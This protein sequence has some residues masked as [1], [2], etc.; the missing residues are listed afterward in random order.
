METFLIDI[1]SKL[2]FI[3][4]LVTIGAAAA[5]GF[6]E[7]NNQK[8]HKKN[9]ALLALIGGFL[10]LLGQCYS[11]KDNDNKTATIIE[12][13]NKIDSLSAINVFLSQG[14]STKLDQSLVQLDSII[15]NSMITLVKLKGQSDKYILFWTWQLDLKFAVILNDIETLRFL[16]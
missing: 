11:T 9:F 7:H 13:G 5:M 4:V 8:P 10:A 12:Q 2:Q 14:N 3:G 16:F 15:D 1:S 6:I